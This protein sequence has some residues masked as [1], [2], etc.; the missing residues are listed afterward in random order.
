MLVSIRTAIFELT[1]E[2]E[3]A[4]IWVIGRPTDRLPSKMYPFNYE[5]ALHI[6]HPGMDPTEISRALGIVPTS[7]CRVGEAKR[8]PSGEP[9]EGNYEATHWYHKFDHPDGMLLSAFL[10]VLTDRLA[11]YAT[12]FST[13][14]SEGGSLVLSVGW[15]S[16][17]NSGDEFGWELLDKFAQL[18]IGL[19]FDIYADPDNSSEAQGLEQSGA[20]K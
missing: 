19:S 20:A 4:Q 11:N 1:M 17:I 13:V 15:Y 9:L 5:V 14:S 3:S 16:G 8:T 6:S 10:D 12:L 2:Q 7:A 18:R